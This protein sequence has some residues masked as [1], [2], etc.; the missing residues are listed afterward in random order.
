MIACHVSTLV[1]QLSSLST[2]SLQVSEFG[3]PTL[4]APSQL[5]R[6]SMW[7][8]SGSHSPTL[9]PPERGE[10]LEVIIRG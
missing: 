1:R 9:P 7:P 8:L 6:L 2:Q 10:E 3:R 4:Q 5:D